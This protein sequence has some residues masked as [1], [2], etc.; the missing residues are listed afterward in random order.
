MKT[1][2]IKNESTVVRLAPATLFKSIL[3][4]IQLPIKV[5]YTFY[6][7][8]LSHYLYLEMAQNF[9]NQTTI[10]LNGFLLAYSHFLTEVF[11]EGDHV[12]SWFNEE[13]YTQDFHVIRRKDFGICPELS[14]ESKVTNMN[15]DPMLT[16]STNAS[17]CL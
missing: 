10:D 13:Y 6:K 8:I 16:H 2:P 14:P 7:Y 5:T 11:V 17:L 1:K 12:Q 3:Q 4:Q 15:R 9:A